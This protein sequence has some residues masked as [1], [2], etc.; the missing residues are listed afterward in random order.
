MR[1]LPSVLESKRLTLRPVQP[2]DVDALH[3]AYFAD[4]ACSRFLQRT[5]HRTIAQ[6]SITLDRLTRPGVYSAPGREGWVIALRGLDLAIG[7]FF[8]FQN[9]V[10]HTLH[11]GIASKYWGRGLMSEAACT[12]I[13]ML[14]QT[15][16]SGVLVGFCESTHHASRRVFEKLGFR[17]SGACDRIGV[18]PAFGP[19]PRKCIGFTLL[20]PV[21]SPHW[22][23]RYM[24]A[25]PLPL[26]QP[27]PTDYNIGLPEE[28]CDGFPAP[29][30]GPP[31]SG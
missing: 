15:C 27:G 14:R 20:L 9:T 23:S 24:A 7:V 12:V 21:G 31:G 1:K 18:F 10:G 16:G 30:G 28:R 6:T 17:Q 4:A 29:P 3:A 5:Q 22:L 11:F 19:F 26:P 13:D 25:A 2:E 8:L